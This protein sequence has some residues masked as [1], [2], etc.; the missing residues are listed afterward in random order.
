MFLEKTANKVKGYIK[1]NVCGFFVERFLN[2]ALKENIKLWDIKKDDEA[3][4]SALT[5]IYEYKKLVEIAKK[6]GC[7]INIEKKVGVPFFIMK[8]KK[9]KPFAIFFVLIAVLIYILSLHIW[10]I[11]IV[12]NFTF[13]IEDVKKELEME[14]VKIGTL[15][16]N[17]DVDRIKNNIYMRRHDIAWIGISFKGTSAIVEVVQGNLKEDDELSKVPCNIVSTKEGMIYKIDAWEGTSMFKSGDL[18]KVGDILIS[19]RVSSEWSDDRYVSAKGTVLLKTW[20]TKIVKI[21]Y[22]RDIISK[23]GNEERKYILGIKN[24]EI[25]LTNN[26]TKF[27][28]YDKIISSNKL[29][30]FGKFEMPIELTKIVYQE[31]DVDT[32]RYTK[33]QAILSAKSEIENNIIKKL[34]GVKEIVDTKI[35]TEENEDGIIVIVTIECIEETGT[36]QRLEGF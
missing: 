2:L 33:D 19:S 12:G 20:Y 5:Y 31:V 18:V 32:V 13:A 15:K 34:E 35:K 28:K 17:L 22:E 10:N 4:A 9:R 25:N 23:T 1:I 6:T 3:G 29:L 27:E 8:H 26:D 7:R 24:Y 14:N 36:K 16:K 30:L 11:E 21:P